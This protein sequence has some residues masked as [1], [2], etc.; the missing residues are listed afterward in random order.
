M[1]N[2]YKESMKINRL[3]SLKIGEFVRTAKL[4]SSFS[5]GHKPQFTDETFKVVDIKTTRLVV[6]FELKDLNVEK[7]LAS[8][9]PRSIQTVFCFFIS[10]I[11]RWKPLLLSCIPPHR[12]HFTPGTHLQTSRI[13]YTIKKNWREN[14]KWV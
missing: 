3:P 9:I 11:Q 8:F 5:K 12:P 10:M 4:S 2:L 14:G 1:K 13:S 7:S 6:S